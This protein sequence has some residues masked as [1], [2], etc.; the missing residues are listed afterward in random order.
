[1]LAGANLAWVL[2]LAGGGVVIP[3]ATLG[4]WGQVARILP[5]GALGDGLRAAL[6]D[7]RVDGVAALVLVVWAGCATAAVARLF[8]WD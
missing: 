5:S 2:L 7:A 8:R 3:T 4:G 6:L 1:V